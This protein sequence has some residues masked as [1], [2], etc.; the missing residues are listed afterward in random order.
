MSDENSDG[1]VVIDSKIDTS[2]IDKGVKDADSKLKKLKDSF[3]EIFSKIHNTIQD[4][5]SSALNKIKK[6]FSD[7]FSK[8][9]DSIHGV[10]ETFSKM[11][12]V[13]QGPVAAAKLIKDSIGKV[14]DIVKEMTA[15][16][17]DQQD[18]EN[19]LA[20]AAK[21]NPYYTAESVQNLK[22]YARQLESVTELSYND[23][24]NQSKIL[25]SAGRTES[26]VTKIMSA[27]ADYAAGAQVD[28]ATAVTTLNATYSGTIGLLGRQV[29]G[30]NGLTASQLANGDAVD[31]IAKKYKGMASELANTGPAAENARKSFNAA[32]G[33]FMAPASDAWNN[34][35][36]NF[37]TK[38]AEVINKLK[39]SPE[40]KIKEGTATSVDYKTELEEAKKNLELLQNAY[41]NADTDAAASHGYLTGD[42]IRKNL[43]PSIKNA[44]NKVNSLAKQYDTLTAAENAASENAKKTA[45]ANKKLAD[46]EQKNKEASDYIT[47]NTKDRE[48]SISQLKLQAD[49]DGKAVD[50]AE[51]LNIYIKS[52]VDLISNSD[53]KITANNSAAKDLLST[54]KEIAKINPD[55]F[56]ANITTELDKS[57]DAVKAS[58]GDI[59]D[60]YKEYSSKVSDAIKTLVSTGVYSS[61]SDEIQKLI[62]FMGV[63]N[64]KQKEASGT[65]TEQVNKYN[66]LSKQIDNLG[67]YSG[68]TFDSL[69]QSL[70][71]TITNSGLA[72]DQIQKLT[73]KINAAKT[74]TMNWKQAWDEAG[75]SAVQS[76]LSA[77]ESLAEAVVTGEDAWGA[78]ASAALNGI[79]SSIEGIGAQLAQLAG[80]YTV[81]AL[82]E[83][84]SQQYPAAA[85]HAA[86]AVTAGAESAAVYAA[87]GLVKGW[88]ANFTTGG[89][90]GGN[91]YTGDKVKANLNSKEMVLNNGQQRNLFDR[92]NNDDLG[93]SSRL[94][95]DEIQAIA[96]SVAGL[97]NQNVS[98]TVTLDKRVLAKAVSTVTRNGD[99]N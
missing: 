80:L 67:T 88:A 13:M 55:T 68:D 75:S 96:S 93:T 46:A 28:I 5:V 84:W 7:T 90:A 74:S 48:K 6:S 22:N 4:N 29:K 54:I 72:A 73:D 94:S 97:Y 41:K 49:L 57:V 69:K 42:G 82:G 21:N 31:L 92:I 17:N 24:L 20:L 18:A 33:Q 64:E 43:L 61:D 8:I 38:G 27:A 35:W 11:R 66:E 91:S 85:G 47:Q 16:Y 34:F 60:V 15:A 50:N 14:V 58:G 1:K 10:P 52:Y 51:L 19:G 23:I 56:I 98:T 79:A 37:Y 81:L 3:S 9:K 99:Y 39:N 45:D 62:N 78:F 65:T 87:A 95:S 40:K 76:L 71:D 89:I 30:L 77:T 59:A 63:L 53:G 12:D 2:G 32:V 25:I 36:K 26:E 70:L 83:L 86:A 44:E